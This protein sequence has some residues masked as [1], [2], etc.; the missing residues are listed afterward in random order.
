VQAARDDF[1]WIS[2]FELECHLARFD[3]N[4]ASGTGHA[5]A[6]WRGRKVPELDFR[7]DCS[8]V[9]SEQGREQFAG[10]AFKLAN[11]NRR[12]EDLRHA[13]GGEIDCVLL[14]NDEFQLTGRADS[15]ERPHTCELNAKF[16]AIVATV[17]ELL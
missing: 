14:F 17:C 3:S 5:L 6:E 15:R 8:F 2:R 10:S 9:W 13:A 7:A 11:Q 12:A 16:S 1:H 4:D